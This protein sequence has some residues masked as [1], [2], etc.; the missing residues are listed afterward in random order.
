MGVCDVANALG[1]LRFMRLHH[2]LSLRA[3]RNRGRGMLT[4]IAELMNRNLA[5][6]DGLDIKFRYSFTKK[7][8]VLNPVPFRVYVGRRVAG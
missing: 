6:L 8:V 7:A 4:S 5:P 1:A 3:A 2:T